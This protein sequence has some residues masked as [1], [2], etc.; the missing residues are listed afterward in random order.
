MPLEWNGINTFSADKFLIKAT[1]IKFE[2]LFQSFY[3]SSLG[4]YLFIV[5]TKLMQKDIFSIF[6][7]LRPD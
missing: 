7:F 2:C 5:L 4:L 3:S 6:Y 1:Q